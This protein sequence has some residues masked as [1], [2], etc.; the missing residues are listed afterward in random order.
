MRLL[1]VSHSGVISA[2]RERER[3]LRTLGVDVS[4]VTSCRWNEGGKDVDFSADADD[5][6]V[7][8]RTFGRHPNAFVFDPRP[9]W[10]LL[11]KDWDVLDV[12]E[13]PCSLATA[14]LLV[15]R[16]LHARRIPFLL[17]SAQNIRK[18][19]P[20]P[21][22]WIERWA[23]R[24][25]AGVYVCNGEAGRILRGKGLRGEMCEIPL[26]VDTTRFAPSEHSPPNGVLRIGYV[27]RLEG[28]KGV[29][30]LIEAVS[31]IDETTLEI[32]G[33]G[34][35]AEALALLSTTLGLSDRV[36]FRGFVEQRDLPELYRSFDV[37]AVPSLPLPGWLEQFC[38]VA[39]EAMATGIPVVASDTGALPEVVGDGGLL[40]PPGNVEALRGVL[41][42]LL[43]EPD[44]WTR[45]RQAALDN[46]SR[47]A[48]SV[49]AD[50]HRRLYADVV[51]T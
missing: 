27:G 36:R 23:L 50:A 44:L 38:R 34:P 46:A 47:F 25:A 49:V 26:G 21:F 45:T 12:H 33:A 43:D 8:V 24:R 6:A 20:V 31:A 37:V 48:W 28:H 29:A 11:G 42:R 14:E 51:N 2:W 7:P 4:L 17:Y 15:L 32:I 9:L 39:V 19:Y 41:R 5:F 40:F 13:E 35:E 18:R 10:R 16:S 1:R 3:V 22:R 30:S